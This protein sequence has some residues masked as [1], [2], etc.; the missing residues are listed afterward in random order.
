MFLGVLMFARNLLFRPSNSSSKFLIFLSLSLIF[1]LDSYS[2]ICSWSRINRISLYFSMTFLLAFSSRSTIWSYIFLFS[3]CFF[4]LSFINLYISASASCNCCRSLVASK[5]EFE[6][7]ERGRVGVGGGVGGN[8]G[9]CCWS[10]CL[11]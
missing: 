7:C 2:S 9:C 4:L 3:C 1:L 6:D 8:W 5:L 11:S 10:D